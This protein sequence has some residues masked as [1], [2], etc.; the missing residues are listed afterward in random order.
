MIEVKYSN[1]QAQLVAT[2]LNQHKQQNQKIADLAGEAL[3][4]LV[5]ASKQE[6]QEN[7]EKETEN[8]ERPA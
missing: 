8:E 1:E 4:R 5:S 7:G 6:A 3:D 2:L